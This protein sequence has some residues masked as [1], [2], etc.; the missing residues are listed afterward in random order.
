MS[1]IPDDIR[2]KALEV[3]MRWAANDPIFNA[4]LADDIAEA[5]MAERERCSPGDDLGNGLVA[6]P[7]EPTERMIE[8]ARTCLKRL[9]EQDQV[10]M[11]L[12][13]HRDSHGLK[14]RA[15]WKAMIDAAK[16]LIRSDKAE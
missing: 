14:M 10:T 9:P 15:R 3:A 16:P 6:V 5:L 13:S 4:T 7:V 11:T 12:G 1:V 2:A 8:M